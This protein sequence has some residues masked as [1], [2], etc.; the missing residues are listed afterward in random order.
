MV[1]VSLLVHFGSILLR[2]WQNLEWSNQN[3]IHASLLGRKWFAA[4]ML[5]I[6]FSRLA[7]RRISIILPWSWEKLLEQETDAAGFLGIWMERDPDTGIFGN[8]TGGTHTLYHWSNGLDVGTVTPKWTPAEASPLV[9]NSEGAPA[10]G[11]FSYSSVVRMLLYLSD[12]TRPDIAYAVN[13]AAWY[14]FC[15]KKSHEGA[16]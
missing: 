5:M 4:L 9:K 13:C 12:H 1:F 16:Y 15:P 10:T 7:I 8:E 3:L 11:K 2:K 14:M 6:W